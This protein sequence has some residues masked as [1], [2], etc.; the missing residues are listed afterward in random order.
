MAGS[1]PLNGLEETAIKMSALYEK[2]KNG[3][4][5]DSEIFEAESEE[6]IQYNVVKNLGEDLCNQKLWK[7]YIN[8]V[9]TKTDKV[10]FL[11]FYNS[12]NP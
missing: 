2:M 12:L 4:A 7:L 9:K 1:I 10:C 6:Y 11:I 5:N 3:G 8:F